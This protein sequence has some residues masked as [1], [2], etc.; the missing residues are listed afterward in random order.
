M[1]AQPGHCTTILTS[2]VCSSG[3]GVKLPSRRRFPALNSPAFPSVRRISSGF[4][5]IEL[6]VV[7]A[8]IAVLMGLAFPAFQSV[9]NAAKKTQAKNDLSQIMTAVNAFYT[10]YGVYPIDPTITQSDNDVEY[11]NPDSPVHSNSEVMNALRAI[12]DPNG[13]PNKGHALNY[14]KVVFLNGPNVK[15][16]ANPRAGFDAA[17][18]FWDPWGKRTGQSPTIGHYV[19]N[20]DA[21]YDGVTQAYTLKYTD[22]TY[23]T[24]T[25]KGPGTGTGVRA[26]VIGASVGKDGAYGRVQG[27]APNGNNKLSGSDDVLSWQ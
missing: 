17:G 7:I 26:G 23:D 4:T 3:F 12:D 19:I 15:D 21:N 8:I 27:T 1:E 5:L 13:G 2:R 6:L 14:K 25:S 22:L 9:Q 10:E 11:G 18:E 20:V 24:T 16:Q